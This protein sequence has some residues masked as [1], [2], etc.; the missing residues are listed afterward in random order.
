MHPRRN[1][2]GLLVDAAILELT[3][4]EY[5]ALIGPISYGDT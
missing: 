2:L 1:E 5:L 3:P 4:I